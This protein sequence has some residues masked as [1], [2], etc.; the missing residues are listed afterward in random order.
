MA[1]FGKTAQYARRWL[2]APSRWPTNSDSSIAA[3]PRTSADVV[4]RGREESGKMPK[5]WLR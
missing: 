3:G 2:R 5:D 1:A 4:H